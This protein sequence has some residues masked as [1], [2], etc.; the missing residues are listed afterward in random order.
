VTVFSTV[1][2]GDITP[3]SEA[4]RIVLIV[5]MLGDLASWVPACEYCCRPCSAA[6]SKDRVQAAALAR[7]LP[8]R[9]Q[10]IQGPRAQ[11]HKLGAR[12]PAGARAIGAITLPGIAAD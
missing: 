3:R 10:R 1:G 12:C 11:A 4:A 8:D 2:F 5:Q 7:P 6:G 9:R